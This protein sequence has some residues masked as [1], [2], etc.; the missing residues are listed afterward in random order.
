[1]DQCAIEPLL[2]TV[3]GGISTSVPPTPVLTPFRRSPYDTRVSPFV[4]G[5]PLRF[6]GP[7]QVY[8]PPDPINDATLVIATRFPE[9]APTASDPRAILSM[10]LALLR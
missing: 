5:G 6:V 4:S 10:A 8:A 9:I 7:G 3:A 2:I 1:M